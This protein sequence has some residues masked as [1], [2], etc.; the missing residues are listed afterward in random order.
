MKIAIFPLDLG[1]S[2]LCNFLSSNSFT[3][4]RACGLTPCSM[5]SEA[6]DCQWTRWRSLGGWLEVGILVCI[7]DMPKSSW[8]NDYGLELHRMCGQAE[9]A[10]YMFF[11]LLFCS[12][13]CS[14]SNCLARD[15]WDDW[16]RAAKR[17]CRQFEMPWDWVCKEQ[18]SRPP[19]TFKY[20]IINTTSSPKSAERLT[21]LHLSQKPMS[22]LSQNISV[23]V[24]VW[25]FFPGRR[26]ET[27]STAQGS[28]GSK[29]HIRNGS[30][31]EPC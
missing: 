31:L 28:Q 23:S 18:T 13:S 8:W 3:A 22:L 9:Q 27:S 14:E 16:A 12:A 2:I 30:F 19:K 11:L 1:S 7:I 25:A 26:S 21:G 15:T 20:Q 17:G 10:S 5:S 24:L 4:V 29:P 6:M